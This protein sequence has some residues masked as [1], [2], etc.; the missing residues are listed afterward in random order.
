MIQLNEWG[1]GPQLGMKIYQAY[2]EETIVLIN[3]KSISIN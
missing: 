3:R 2:R 1:F